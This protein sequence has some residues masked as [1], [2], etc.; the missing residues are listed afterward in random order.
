MGMDF[1]PPDSA[2]RLSRWAL[3]VSVDIE[4]KALLLEELLPGAGT[5]QEGS[6]ALDNGDTL[7]WLLTDPG[8]S[9]AIRTLP[10][11]IDW[12]GGPTPAARL[13]D[14]GCSLSMLK[15]SLP[16]PESLQKITGQGELFSF[17]NS[18]QERLE[19]T[20]TGPAGVLLITS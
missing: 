16:A 3:A 18:P 10:F 9:P 5:V 7:R 17:E 20:I 12:L 14:S 2:G 4:E 15:I 8:S 13:P 1:L 6:R 19:A 11:L